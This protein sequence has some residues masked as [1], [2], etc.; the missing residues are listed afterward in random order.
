METRRALAFYHINVTMIRIPSCDCFES[1]RPEHIYHNWSTY[2]C[3]VPQ[4]LVALPFS[5]INTCAL[6]SKPHSILSIN[7]PWSSYMFYIACLDQFHRRANVCRAFGLTWSGNFLSVPSVR[8]L[9]ARREIAQPKF[10]DA[11]EPKLNWIRALKFRFDDTHL[12]TCYIC[13]VVTLLTYVY[14]LLL[15]RRGAPGRLV[16]V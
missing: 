15:A 12:I 1:S 4:V 9:A 16:A 11:P 7:P 2:N 14:R 6:L 3:F 5:H 13:G 10:S 8:R